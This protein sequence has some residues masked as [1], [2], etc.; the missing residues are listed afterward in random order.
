MRRKGLCVIL[1]LAMLFSFMP[2]AIY[3]ADSWTAHTNEVNLRFG[4]FADSHVKSNATTSTTEANWLA[5][6]V[7]A[8][9][10]L[11]GGKPDAYVTLG[12]L[13]WFNTNEI[14]ENAYDVVKAVFDE[15]MV[16]GVA[17][18]HAMGNHEFPLSNKDMTVAAA[19]REL[20][21]EKMN[22]TPDYV[23]EV[24]GYKFIAAAPDNYN[25]PKSPELES[26]I[27]TEIDKAIVADSTNANADGTF[28]EG[29]IPDSTKPVF[30][31]VHHANKDARD[32]AY[33]LFDEGADEAGDRLTDPYTSQEFADFFGDKTSG[34]MLLWS[35]PY[36]GAGSRW[37]VPDG[38]HSGCGTF[39]GRR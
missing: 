16:E 25:D 35:S 7:Q 37:C 23:T 2:S 14:S 36:G 26:W 17:Q 10:E 18:I 19:A 15:N 27:M 33:P 31:A 34:G 39:D 12:D 22:Q 6:A 5:K 30:L 8:T 28:D 20:F 24:N 11:S 13:V 1:T 4:V 29:V 38:L 9:N 32:F 3:A 21:E